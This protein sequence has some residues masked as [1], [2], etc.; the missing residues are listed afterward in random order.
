MIPYLGDFAED[1]E[2]YIGFNTFT[3]SDPAI[4]STVTNLANADIKV[5]K[6]GSA[7]PLTTDGATLAIDFG[8]TGCHMIT[9]ATNAHADYS[10]GS[11]FHVRVEGVTIDTGADIDFFVGHFSIENRIMGQPAG[12]TLSVDIA[13][14]K[15]ETVLIVS[16]TESGTFGLAAIHT[17]S[18]AIVLDTESGT[19]GLAQ[20]LIDTEATISDTE[21]VLTDTEATI[22]DTEFVLTDAEAIVADT[23][24]GASLDERARCLQL[25]YPADMG[26]TDSRSTRG[27]FRRVHGFDQVDVLDLDSGWD[28]WAAHGCL[29]LHL[30]RA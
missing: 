18:E 11:D 10:V 26:L 17:D 6:D 27:C 19:H 15:A 23:E 5:H 29:R 2:L 22:S 14:L 20:L 16:D 25:D 3:S 9:I 1:E 28:L 30:V 12:A 13:A 8:G 4:S 24:S 21:F 7:T